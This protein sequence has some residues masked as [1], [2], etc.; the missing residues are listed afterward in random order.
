MIHYCVDTCVVC[1][2]QSTHFVWCLYVW[3]FLA[4]S[5]LDRSWSPINEVGQ[6]LLPD[7]LKWFVNLGRIDFSLDDI[8]DGHV[9][10]LSSGGAHHNVV[11]MQEPS[12]NVEDSCFANVWHLTLDSQRRITSHQKV[13][14]WGWNQ[15][16][17]QADHIVVHIA[18]ISECSGGSGHHR[19]DQ[20]V[21][22][23]KVRVWNL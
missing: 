7:S 23:Q 9:F 13:A 10:S 8:Q 14:S 4:E 2:H 17:K 21:D 5:H 1:H 16:G 12:H 6:F 22:L 11:W 3:A 15:R 18:R 19:R 20:R